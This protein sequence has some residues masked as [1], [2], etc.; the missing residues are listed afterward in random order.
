MSAEKLSDTEIR[1]A[2]N[3]LQGWELQ[4]GEIRKLYKFKDFKE[5]LSF[6]NRVAELA[7]EADHH[8]DILIRYNKVT[9]T[10]STHSAG[11]LTVKDF[12]LAQKIDG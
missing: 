12:Q 9:L 7:E 2:L 8:P 5:A 6:V 4:E 11:G 3:S 1:K 10:L